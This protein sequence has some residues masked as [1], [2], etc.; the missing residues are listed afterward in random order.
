MTLKEIA[1]PRRVAW[2]SLAMW[3]AL[4]VLTIVACFMLVSEQAYRE[5]VRQQ[6]RIETAPPAPAPIYSDNDSAAV[7]VHWRPDCSGECID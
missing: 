7:F 6:H 4:W 3:H 5:E 1:H 2:P